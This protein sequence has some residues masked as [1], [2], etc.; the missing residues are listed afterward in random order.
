LAHHQPAGEAGS[1]GGGFCQMSLCNKLARSGLFQILAG[2]RDPFFPSVRSGGQ[3]V[4]ALHLAL[5]IYPLSLHTTRHG[6]KNYNLMLI[7][8]PSLVVEERELLLSD[9]YASESMQNRA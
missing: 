7:L 9:H 3:G 8:A 1:E 2:T 4:S 6:V 5:F